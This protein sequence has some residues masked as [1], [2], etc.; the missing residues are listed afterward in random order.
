MILK[1]FGSGPD[2]Y[3]DNTCP[4]LQYESLARNITLEQGNSTL[5]TDQLPVG[6]YR[7]LGPVE[8]QDLGVRVQINEFGVS[9]GGRMT[10]AHFNHRLLPRFHFAQL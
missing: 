4:T 6:S 9:N 3:L 1:G 8:G 2:L 5:N 10:S 7:P